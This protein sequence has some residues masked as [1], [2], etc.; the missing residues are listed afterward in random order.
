M[1][2]DKITA[3]GLGDGGVSTADIADDAVTLNK[4]SA[5]GT[6]DATTF[7][8]GD[9]SFQVVAVTPTAV[10]DQANTS[11]GAFDLPSGTTAQRPG[12]PTS[13]YTR[14]NTDLGVME[15]YDGSAWLKVSSV[16]SVLTSVTGNIWS[17]AVG[18][19]LTLAGTGFLTSDL[20][21]NFLQSSDSIDINV[22]VTPSSDTAATV[23]IPSTVYSNVT[24]GN[25]VSVKVTNSDGSASTAIS[26]TAA[27][28]PSGGTIAT[29]G[30][31]R[32]HTFLSSGT[33]VNT[34][35]TSAEYLIVAGGGGTCSTGPTGTYP[36]AW[37]GGG[38]AGGLITGTKTG[39]S[40]TSYSMVV[41]SGGGQS[42]SG[43]NSSG[44]SLTANGGGKGGE[45]SAAGTSGGCGGGGGG[46]TT[47]AGG[48]GT[49]GQG[50]AGGT[51]YDPGPESG[52]GGGGV[53]GVGQNASSSGG[54]DGGVGDNMSAWASATSTGDGGYYASGGGGGPGTT[55]ATASV[56]SAGGGGSGASGGYSANYNDAENGAT[57]T[58]GGGGG[59]NKSGGSGIVIIRYDITG[60]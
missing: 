43:G 41:G 15:N 34:L 11:T 35:V 53:G 54:G 23:T 12:S 25:V 6:K 51:G 46:D 1:A 2:I 48:S 8:R 20:I 3:S 24:A 55:N 47:T 38:G 37:G 13:G 18:S 36:Q 60:I 28:L 59:G 7:L 32:Y 31:Y 49:V 39:L 14:F 16:I 22:T 4:L 52:G 50:Y 29:S 21:V 44:F 33:Y 27:A 17:G 56:G 40:A 42:T 58:G 5:S 19:G 57:N 9:D 30:N 26:K 10:S 45:Y